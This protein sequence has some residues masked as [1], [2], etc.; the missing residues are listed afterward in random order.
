TSKK[1]SN[2]EKLVLFNS[3]LKGYQEEVDKLTREPNLEKMLFLTF[4][5]NFMKHQ[6]PY[7]V[8]TSIAEDAKLS[9]LESENRKM[10]VELEE[11]R[12][13]STHLKNQQ[14]T[15]RR[16]KK[17]TR[18]LEQQMEEKVKEIVDIKQRNLAEENQK[19]MEVLKECVKK[20]MHI[21]S[22]RK[23][24][25]KDTM[26]LGG[27]DFFILAENGCCK[28]SYGKLKKVF[29]LCGNCMNLPQSQLFELRALSEEERASKQSE[30]NLL[31]D[32][33]EQAQTRLLS[34]EREK[35]ANIVETYRRLSTAYKF[36]CA[37][38]VSHVSDPVR[39]CRVC[40]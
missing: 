9:E 6:I 28:I 18:Q 37:L 30:V 26:L 29:P 22:P 36:G 2:E 17:R 33:V 34:L 21:I 32:E 7:P 35:P 15:I 40:L 31:M 25:R 1:A 19:T 3:L 4:T 23:G 16:L 27:H 38:K 11:F 14:A 5:R 8:L 24:G 39:M 10:K 20:S 12:T 13:E